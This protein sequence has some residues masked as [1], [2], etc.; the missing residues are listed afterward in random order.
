M[1]GLAGHPG[2]SE[3]PNPFLNNPTLQTP[4]T[5]HKHGLSPQGTCCKILA[6]SKHATWAK[7]YSAWPTLLDSA[8]LKGKD[9]RIKSVLLGSPEVA[10][11][12]PRPSFLS[13][14]SHLSTQSNPRI[15]AACWPSGWG[16]LKHQPGAHGQG[17]CSL[18]W[19][20]R[21]GQECL[22]EDSSVARESWSQVGFKE[23]QRPHGCWSP[24]DWVWALLAVGTRSHM[25]LGLSLHFSSQPRAPVL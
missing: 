7:A 19:P 14:Y 13:S 24:I 11:T 16:T 4:L 20:L 9:S 5:R 12:I 23:Q 22:P 18:C 25:T 21:N 10:N 2:F 3:R 6:A 1:W 17:E 8:A 15:L